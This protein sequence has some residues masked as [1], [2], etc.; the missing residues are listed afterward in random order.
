[1]KMWPFLKE[2]ILLFGSQQIFDDNCTTTYQEVLVEVELLAQRLKGEKCC[3][4]LCDSELM[5]AKALL[6]CFAAN[7]TAVP[8]SLRY[9]EKYC[10]NIIDY[11]QPTAVITDT[12][13][14]LNLVRLSGKYMEPDVVPALIMCTSGTTGS[15]K[16]V[17]LTEENIMANLMDIASY[18]SIDSN[19]TI[20]ISRPLYHCA[21]LTGEFLVS[22]IK[23]VSICF[24]S[25]AFNP[26]KIWA[27]IEG[28]RVTV[29]AGTPTMFSLMIKVAKKPI[30]NSS[31]RVICV[32]GECL[33]EQLGRYLSMYLPHV[34]IYHVY[35]LTEAS[36][37]VS[38]LPPEL[39]R[40][41]PESVGYLLN[42]LQMKI[43][44]S[45]GEVAKTNELGVLWIRG[46]N[47]T[48]GYFNNQQQTKNVIKDGWLCT[49]D[50]AYVDDKGLLYIKGR[51]DELIIRAGMNIYPQEI[52]SK[53]KQDT[54]V[55]N[56][57]VYGYKDAILGDQIGME[58]VGDFANVDEVKRM[59]KELLPIFQIPTRIKI[60]EKIAQNCSGKVVRKYEND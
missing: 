53:I 15:P 19:D 17:M 45:N 60:V 22:L 8:L 57:L 31:L 21:V 40:R 54:R 34:D 56:V 37:R 28:Y 16:G 51:S 46:T 50:I 24:I 3:A 10:Q 26:K 49:G 2:K 30:K 6:A 13:G 4:I 41:N 14:E 12:K 58:I 7:V 38:W 33:G 5:G 11:I 43:I 27:T 42:S 20:L 48:N 52:E 25:K 29:F 35:G 59:C 47:V 18:F 44:D 36:P 39:F 55:A 23:G 32:S 9:G 1:M